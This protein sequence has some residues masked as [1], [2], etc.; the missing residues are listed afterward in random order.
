[1]NFLDRRRVCGS[2]GSV[3]IE[4]HGEESFGRQEL[5]GDLHGKIV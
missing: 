2:D 4:E 1:M 3:S 5:L